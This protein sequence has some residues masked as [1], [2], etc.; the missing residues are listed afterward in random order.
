MPTWLK[1]LHEWATRDPVSRFD[2]PKLGELIICDT[3]RECSI[4]GPDGP[5]LLEVGGRYEPDPA[6]LE[7]ARATAGRIDEFTEEVKT[8][9]QRQTEA[10]SEKVSGPALEMYRAEASAL[11]MKSISSWW[12][13]RPMSGMIFFE[14]PDECKQWRCDIDEGELCNLRN[15][16]TDYDLN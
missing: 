9:L 4:E 11:R 8:F 10:V 13:K 1:R 7:T 3:G 2:D 5:I 14:G 6:I 15:K 12:P 16:G